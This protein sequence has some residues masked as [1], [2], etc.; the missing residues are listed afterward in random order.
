M[1][2]RGATGGILL[3][4]KFKNFGI[5]E[6]L[7]PK[8]KLDFDSAYK[9]DGYSLSIERMVPNTLMKRYYDDGFVKSVRFVGYSLP[10][11][12]EDSVGGAPFKEKV[13]TF[14]MSIKAKRNGFLPKIGWVGDVIDGKQNFTSISTI[15]DW[16]VDTVKVEVEINNKRRTL[17]IGKPFKLNPNIEVTDQVA[18]GADGH[19]VAA[20][21]FSIAAD[22]G[23]DLLAATKLLGAL[24]TARDNILEATQLERAK[25]SEMQNAAVSVPLPVPVAMTT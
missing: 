2:P 13:G 7:V 22:I 25:V 5:R 9:S 17:D 24:S 3:L 12:V 6:F 16:Q 14:E 15:K 8:L 20:E 23:K 21:M 1:V 10:A 4:Q 11:G 19:P 18:K